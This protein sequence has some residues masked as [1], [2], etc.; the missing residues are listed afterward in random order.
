[1]AVRIIDVEKG[2]PAH[3]YNIMPGDE[4]VSINGRNI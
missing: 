4:L 3:K 2:T 1:M